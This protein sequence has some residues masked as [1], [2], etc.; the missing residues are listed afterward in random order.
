MNYELMVLFSYSIVPA[1]L[2]GVS[3]FRFINSC[4]HPFIIY[5]SIGL[6]NEIV[7]SIVIHHGY[8]NAVNNNIFYLLEGWLLLMQFYRWKLF[9]DKQFLYPICVMLMILLWLPYNIPLE[10][11]Q[12][13]TPW[14][15]SIEGG[16]IMILAIITINRHI[17][18]FDGTLIRSPVFLISI[19]F[20]IYFSTVILMEV[21]L[22]YGSTKSI[23]LQDAIFK[24]SSI[25]N[26]ITNLLYLIA[27]LCIPS[28]PR[29]IMQ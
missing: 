1:F 4:Y 8:S 18:E 20:C 16:I 12:T 6:V 17:I 23:G 28:K 2:A 25:I 22:Y 13:Y 7:S 27:I 15:R 26:M 29:F 10:K 14:F 24:A 19:G 5:I 11:L 21:F 3:R 9:G